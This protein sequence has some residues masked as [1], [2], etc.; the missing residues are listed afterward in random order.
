MREYIIRRILLFILT[1]L[2]ASLVIF[3]L[4]RVLPGDL[5]M[6]KFRS[7]TGEVHFYEE[8]AQ[9]WR[10]EWGLN[11]PLPIQYVAWI[12]EL[13][14]G[15]LGET[16]VYGMYDQDGFVPVFDQLKR[17]LPVSLQLSLLSFAAILIL[18]VPIGILAGL[19]PD[20]RLDYVMR[21]TSVLFLA[22]PTFFVGLLVVLILHRTFG[23]LPTIGFTHLWEN[24]WASCQQLVPPAV[25]LGTGCCGYFLILTRTQLLAV[26]RE[27]YIQ[28][29]RAEG[30]AEKDIIIRHG[31]PNALLPLL[32][33]AGGQFAVLFSGIVVIEAIFN[34]PGVGRGLLEVISW[35]EVVAV[36]SYLMYI[37]TLLLTVNLVADLIYAWLDPRIR[38]ESEE[39]YGQRFSPSYVA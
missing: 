5:Y 28:K 11:R 10:E 18:S 35:G 39:G 19:K 21:G 31:L 12:W 23:W 22:M 20:G 9:E 34:L 2:G 36:P 29:A 16:Y 38:R 33:T 13:A 15:D 6:V 26:F 14:R 25:A 30:M 7:Y 32:A 27:G 17:Q 1:L 3:L 37:A 8:H 24:P 4:L